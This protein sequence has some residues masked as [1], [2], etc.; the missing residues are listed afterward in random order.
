MRFH[1]KGD[2]VHIP[3]SVILVDCADDTSADPQMSPRIGI[4]TSLEPRAGGYVRVFC[5][6][7]TWSVK[8]ESIFLLEGR[9]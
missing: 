3:Q 4:V 6:G 2:L 7:C 1:E 8:K 9:E 5:D